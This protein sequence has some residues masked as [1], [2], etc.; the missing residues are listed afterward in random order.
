VRTGVAL[1]TSIIL[2]VALA[3][4]AARSARAD[5]ASDSED[6]KAATQGK[7]VVDLVE[8]MPSRLGLARVRA[9]VSAMDFN[10]KRIPLAGDPSG[11]GK[12]KGAV[13]IKV[14]SA[15]PSPALPGF[16]E[17][18]DID[19]AL[20]VIVPV[21]AD[22]NDVLPS[23]KEHVKAELL[24]P[25]Q[26]ALGPRVQIAIIGYAEGT[27]GSRRLGNA[28]AAMTALEGLEV[29]STPPNLLAAVQRGVTLAKNAIKKPKNPGDLVR[30]AVVL[31]SDGV[32]VSS[33]ERAAITKLGQT[34]AK[35]HVRIHS[36][37]YSQAGRKRPMF[38]LGEL[39]TQSSGT[40]RWVRTEGGWSDQLGRVLDEL[41]HETVLT[42]FAPP[43]ELA[44]KK[45]VVGVPVAGKTLESEA[46]KLPDS[47]CSG[48]PCDGYCAR[49]VCVI[50]AKA[51]GGGLMSYLLIGGAGLVGLVLL[52]VGG[53]AI[54]RRK[55]ISVGPGGLP[56]GVM[57]PGMPGM[58]GM[59]GG[60][61]MPGAPA[62]PGAVGG[63]PAMPG[64]MPGAP[65]ALIPGV[66]I[67]ILVNG[68]MAGQRVAIKHGMTLGKAPGSDLDL[69]YDSTASGNH[70]MVTFDG[71]TWQLIDRGSTNGTYVNGNRVQQVRL[72]P[73]IIVRLGSTEVR[74]GTA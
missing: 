65:A 68:P 7:V 19:L 48:D 54:A 64:A 38:N 46:V 52:V 14:G 1:A 28:S 62:M 61:V 18:S 11:K 43:D 31:I 45:L 8:V 53:S 56:P 37:A 44:D 49:G 71:S 70:A 42:F 39:S 73:G 30:G 26:K 27:T 57:M 10:G 6:E 35:D 23:V 4:G 22:Y 32:G 13:T 41:L 55:R 50:P 72:D 2:A 67:F 66:P 17:S 34:A 36:V 74:F 40:F 21:T 5:D 9:L 69:S 15:K 16:F 25:L 59:A 58:P 63:L 20:V 29:D 60:L 24:T 33:E 3:F 12:V 51:G 47:E